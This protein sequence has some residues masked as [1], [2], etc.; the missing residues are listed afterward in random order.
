LRYKLKLDP[1]TS[2]NLQVFKH[3]DSQEFTSIILSN[4]FNTVGYDK[5]FSTLSNAVKESRTNYY[6][7]KPGGEV[8][9]HIFIDHSILEVFIDQRNVFSTRVYPSR[10]ESNKIDLVVSRGKAEILQL[11]VWKLKGM[12]EEMGN[13]VCDPGELPTSVRIQLAGSGE[14]DLDFSIYPNPA[15]DYFEL[16]GGFSSG[17]NTTVEMF[18]LTGSVIRRLEFESARFQQ[19]IRI[20]SSVIDPGAYFVRLYNRDGTGIKPIIIN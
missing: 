7:F 1:E 3:E 13:E 6:T 15:D 5:K 17:G 16:K 20:D 18:D 4:R 8:D 14:P 2:L 11:D 10:E 9:V 12:R 19:P